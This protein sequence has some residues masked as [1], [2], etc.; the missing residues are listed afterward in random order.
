MLINWCAFFPLICLLPLFIYFFFW[1]R[2]SLALSPR[3]E[4][5]GVISAHG[6][7]YLPGSSDSPTSTSQV[8]GITGS[9]HHSEL[10]FVF[11]VEMSF[12]V[13]DQFG[14]ELL[15]SSDPPALASESAVITVVSHHVW[16]NFFF[17]FL[18]PKP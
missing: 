8:A 9:R 18:K 7:L 11:L 15:A 16:L 14:L 13:V 1:K 12:L 10:I 4:C 5:S 17:F 6:N 3:L 2:W